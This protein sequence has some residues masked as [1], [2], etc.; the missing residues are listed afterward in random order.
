MN[1]GLRACILEPETHLEVSYST[2]LC[3]DLGTVFT[4]GEIVQLR[5]RNFHLCLAE[6]PQMDPVPTRLRLK[7][8]IRSLPGPR[9]ATT[10]ENVAP[11][12]PRSKRTP[13]TQAGMDILC[14]R[15][16]VK[17]KQIWNHCMFQSVL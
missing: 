5:E 1:G 17:P 6:D 11:I 12:S 15:R 7:L 3:H 9:T 4:E 14:T 8:Y 10:L 13:L 2:A 16:T